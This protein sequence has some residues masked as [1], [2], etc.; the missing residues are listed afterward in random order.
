MFLR[1]FRF[2]TGS[3]K[4]LSRDSLQASYHLRFDSK[5]VRLKARLFLPCQRRTR[6]FRF[7]TGSIKSVSSVV[8]VVVKSVFRFQT[9]SIK[10]KTKSSTSL[11]DEISFDSK[12][13]RLKALQSFSRYHCC[14]PGFDSK[15]VRLKATDTRCPPRQKIRFDSKLVRLKGYDFLPCSSPLEVSIPNW[16][17]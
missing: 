16:F 6:K 10:R 13:V 17:D 1:R 7:Q 12:L 11:L 14:L 8:I 3:I 9:G 5:L 2:Q 4:R 15:L